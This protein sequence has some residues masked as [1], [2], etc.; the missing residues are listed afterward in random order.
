MPVPAVLRNVISQSVLLLSD[1]SLVITRS[2]LA[3]VAHWA[4]QTCRELR[5]G[6]KLR[7]D[8]FMNV[9]GGLFQCHLHAAWYDLDIVVCMM[10]DCHNVIIQPADWDAVKKSLVG[11]LKKRCRQTDGVETGDGDGLFVHNAVFAS[12][13]DDASPSTRSLPRRKLTNGSI[14]DSDMTDTASVASAASSGDSAHCNADAARYLAFPCNPDEVRLM[15]SR[16]R[17]ANQQV[18]ILQEMLASKDR[19]I[20]EQSKLIKMS[21]GARARSE[22]QVE[23]LKAAI[24]VDK[25]RKAS[26]SLALTRVQDE[27]QLAKQ[28]NQLQSGRV[29]AFV[30]EVFASQDCT[31]GADVADPHGARAANTQPRSW[32]RLTPNGAIAVAIRRNLSNC[33]AEDFGL[34]VM[35]DLS[36]QSVLRAECGTASA[37]IS[38]SRLFFEQWKSDAFRN[39]DVIDPDLDHFAF[40]FIHY[41][42]DATNASKVRQKL[43]ALELKASFAV[44]SAHDLPDLCVSADFRTIKRLADV[45]PVHSGTG[46]ATMA[47]T[48]KM[49]DSLQCPTWE[50][51][52]N[53]KDGSSFG[54]LGTLS[55]V[56]KFARGIHAFQ[57]LVASCLKLAFLM[58]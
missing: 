39:A 44:A 27:K 28:I 9:M 5:S 24:A 46:P 47:L 4:A 54:A 20:R 8:E 12:C 58:G 1:R 57:L 53:T 48:K 52:L 38:S 19:R 31:P 42:E 32:S 36:K 22:K 37:L 18:S 2:D 51:F 6:S 30:S 10:E 43:T 35:D 55:A 13:S 17:A 3:V 23:N 25:L 45:L 14:I 49:L 11:A 26:S 15:E 56:C 16:L 33:S 7:F 40:T 21:K 50:T 41:R 34:V 29:D